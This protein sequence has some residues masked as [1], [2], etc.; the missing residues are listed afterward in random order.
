LRDSDAL[1]MYIEFMTL[2]LPNRHEPVSTTPWNESAALDATRTIAREAIEAFSET[3]LWPAHPDDLEDIG[4]DV[5]PLAS[6]YNG[7][8]GVIM[9]LAALRHTVAVNFDLVAASTAIYRCAKAERDNNLF[10]RGSY[11][12][13]IAGPALLAAVY[14]GDD[15]AAEALYEDA[16]NDVDPQ[17]RELF[18]GSPGHLHAIRFLYERTGDQRWRTLATR[19]AADLLSD[20]ELFPDNCRLWVQ[21]IYGLEWSAYLGAGHGFA[22]TA[23]AVLAARGVVDVD[24][25]EF[26]SQVATTARNLADTDGKY[27]NWRKIYGVESMPNLP[28]DRYASRLQWCHG[29]PGF[30]I[31]LDAIP[32]D[33][34][35]LFDELLLQAGE[36]VWLAGPPRGDAGLCHGAAGN[37]WAFLKLYR[38]TNNAKWLQRA[39]SFAMH[40]LEGIGRRRAAKDVPWFSF[41]TGDI[42]TAVYLGACVGAVTDLPMIDFMPLANVPHSERSNIP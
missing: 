32:P 7:A 36:L 13:G 12:I 22:G 38:R 35:P 23:Q 37:G 14:A 28:A 42:G 26:S 16:A 15:E 5:G 4:A 39:R 25:V 18:A 27:V 3:T 10:A 6:L 1:A 34:D 40:A 8:A 41:W 30:I 19:M 11:M 29:A 17:A 21:H 24:L 9:G 33:V 20:F 2:W 31:A